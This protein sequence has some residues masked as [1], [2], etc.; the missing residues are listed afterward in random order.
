MSELKRRMGFSLTSSKIYKSKKLNS[1]CNHCE[2]IN[3][4]MKTEQKGTLE[5]SSFGF[6]KK[7]ENK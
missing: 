4:R 5:H 3:L 2:K 1:N 6:N 7:R